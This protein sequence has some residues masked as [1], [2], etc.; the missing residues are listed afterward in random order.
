MKTNIFPKE[1]GQSPVKYVLTLVLVAIIVIVALAIIGP[2]LDSYFGLNATSTGLDDNPNTELSPN[3]ERP[4]I[5]HPT[6]LSEE[7]V[8]L[9]STADKIFR[10]SCLRF[11]IPAGKTIKVST[12]Y[13]RPEEIHISLVPTGNRYTASICNYVA[14]ADIYVYITY[15]DIPQ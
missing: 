12:L 7:P 2:L 5:W 8:Q 4:K 9:G 10:S 11:R 14:G 13:Q 1:K 6:L 3:V 15:V